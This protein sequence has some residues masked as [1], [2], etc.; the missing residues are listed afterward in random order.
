M[1]LAMVKEMTRARFLSAIEG[2]LVADPLKVFIKR[3]PHK[4]SKLTEGRYRLISAVSLVDALVDRILLGELCRNILKPTN[5]MR[6]PCAIGWAPN[7]GGWRYISLTYEN[8]LSIDRKAWDWTVAE[9]LVRI[10]E[11]FL[12]EM[13]PNAPRWWLLGLSTRFTALFYSA[14]F[15]FPDGMIVQQAAPGIMKSGCLMTLILNSVGQTALHFLASIRSGLD[16]NLNIPL[17]MGD[18]TLQHPFAEMEEYASRLAELAVVKEAE[19][20]EGYSEFIGFLFD[21][22]GFF[23]A[24][25]KKHLFNLR[26]LDPRVSHDVLVQYQYLWYRHPSMLRH[27]RDICWKSDPTAIV[28]DI[29]L[30]DNADG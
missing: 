6:T 12:I 27:I 15:S 20:T 3:E 8:G 4:L 17:S 26:H 29:V 14:Q 21:K 1:R 25:W 16:P 9:W 18:D 11:R 23:P 7:K 13:H 28:P 30:R 2:R 24:Y 19:H 5:I 22:K 10:W